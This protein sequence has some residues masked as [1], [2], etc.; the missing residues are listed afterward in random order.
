MT[1]P[2]FL[3]ITTAI[4]LF[5]APAF[6]RNRTFV[7]PDGTT[8]TGK[9]RG[10]EFLHWIEAA[11]GSVL[12]YNPETKRYETAVITEKGLS[13]SRREYRPSNIRKAASAARAQEHRKLRELWLKRRESEMHRRSGG[14][15]P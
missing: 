2:L 8:F 6:E 4:V 15:Y 1:K 7:Q 14:V 3:M 12:V 5:A 11:D 9:V 13:P 10:D